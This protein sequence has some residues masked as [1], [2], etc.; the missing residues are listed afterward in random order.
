MSCTHASTAALLRD[1]FP[2]SRIGEEA[3]LRWLYDESPSGSVVERN[4]DDAEG[5]AA[6]YAVVPID[7]VSDGTPLAGAL[8]LNTAVHERARGG[9]AFVRLAAETYTAAHDRGIQAIVG[10]A[11]ENSTHGFLTRLEFVTHGPL[12]VTV[13]VP[14]PGRSGLRRTWATVDGALTGDAEAALRSAGPALAAAGRGLSRSWSAETLAWRL[15]APGSRYALHVS[16]GI[17]A[18]STT[19]ARGPLR[20]AVLLAIFAAAPLERAQRAAVVRSACVQHRAV[21]ALHAGFNELAGLR[22]VPLPERLRPSPLNFIA[23]ALDGMPLPAPSRFEFLD[24]DA[25]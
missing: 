21:A 16:D 13:M 17:L 3:Y 2:G 25:Y 5:R 6:H 20:V 23:R 11:N 12:P 14:T 18:V 7:L 10:V 24:F 22:G 4:I 9:G 19:E 1:V 15:R 8:S